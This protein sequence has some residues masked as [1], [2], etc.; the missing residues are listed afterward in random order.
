MKTD[1]SNAT[2][3]QLD[4]D[5]VH[6]WY[7][8][9]LS[10]PDHLVSDLVERFNLSSHSLVLDP[11]VGT[12]TTLVECKK[13]GIDSIGV[14]ANPVTALASRVK[15]TWDISL[16]EFEKRQQEFLDYIKDAI[17]QGVRVK[18]ENGSEQLLLDS[19]LPQPDLS[20]VDEEILEIVLDLIPKN[21]LYTF[22]L[23]L[24]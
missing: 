8:F 6:D 24:P 13:L 1:R 9:V 11:F 12:G 20:P 18:R 16:E 3:Q 7:R 19:L 15:T 10:Y 4:N 23:F 21:S 2:I 5:R 17:G 22:L 14:D